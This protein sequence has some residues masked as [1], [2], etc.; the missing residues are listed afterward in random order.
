MFHGQN[1]WRN[2]ARPVRF[3]NIDARG[4]VFFFLFLVH[5]RL[6]TLIFIVS[7]LLFFTILE[8]FGLTFP[9]S[10]RRMRLFFTGHYRPALS[11]FYQRP[12]IDR[13]GE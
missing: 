3:F 2:S 13:G 8:R 11:K 1:H 12:F 5:I 6:W 4:G 10:L 9:T 7:V